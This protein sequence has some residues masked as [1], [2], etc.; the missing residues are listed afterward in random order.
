MKAV[1]MPSR[2]TMKTTNR[3]TAAQAP[4]SG[5]GVAHA[6]CRQDQLAVLGD[7]QP[8]FAAVMRDHQLL[9]RPEQVGAWHLGGRA[10]GGLHG[11]SA[12]CHGWTIIVLTLFVNGSH[13]VVHK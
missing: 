9:A 6:L 7:A 5:R 1:S 13:D 10:G 12:F 8:V 11:G 3:N 2:V 4:L